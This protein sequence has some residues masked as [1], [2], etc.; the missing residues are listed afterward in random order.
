MGVQQLLEQAK[1][2]ETQEIVDG[3]IELLAALGELQA[4]VMFA[5]PP[6]A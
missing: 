4:A 2:G 5:V 6:D 3:M 1:R